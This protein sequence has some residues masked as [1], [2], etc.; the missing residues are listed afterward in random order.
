MGFT[1]MIEFLSY[2]LCFWY[3]S[4]L[5]EEERYNDIYG[6]PYTM[7]DVLTVFFAIQIGGFSIG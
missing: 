3:G 5:I 4:V 2:A 6:R 1:Y 7:G